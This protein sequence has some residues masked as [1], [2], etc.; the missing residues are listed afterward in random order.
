MNA[1]ASSVSSLGTTPDFRGATSFY[2]AVYHLL[3]PPAVRSSS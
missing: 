2:E 3:D 1:P